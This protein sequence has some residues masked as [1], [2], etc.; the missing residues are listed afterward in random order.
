[1]SFADEIDDIMAERT[2]GTNDGA[3]G[4]HDENLRS[5]QRIAARFATYGKGK[6]MYVHGA[7]WHQWDGSRW[8]P[9]ASDTR[10][11]E[12]LTELLT[13][14]WS[15]AMTDRDLQSDV[16]A[17]MTAMGSRGVLELARA[18]RDLFAEHVDRDPWLL[19]CLNG[20]LDLHTLALR[21]HDPGDRITR[22]CGAAYRPDA[23]APTWKYL[24]ESSLPDGAVRGY[25]QRYAGLALVGRVIEHVLVIMTGEG[26]NGKGLIGHTIGKALG[27]TD[28]YAITGAASMLVAGRYGD[29]PS[30]GE[31]AAQY[32]LRGARWVVLSEIQRGS[33]MDQATMKLLTGGDAIQA[34]RMGMDPID[35]AP[36]HTLAM[37]ANDL[38]MVD[39][40]AKAVWDRLRVIPFTVDFSGREDTTIEERLESELEGVLA[41]CVEGLRDYM[42][43]GRK[44]DAPE[45]VWARTD[46]YRDDNDALG[47]F[48]AEECVEHGGAQ[49]AKSAFADAYA[50]WA[51]HERE[52]KF[53]P[54][55]IAARL[56]KRHGITEGRPNSRTRTWV[57]IGL[58]S[59]DQPD[60]IEP[61]PEPE[62]ESENPVTRGSVT[63]VTS[64]VRALRKS[65]IGNDRDEVTQVTQGGAGCAGSA[66]EAGSLGRVC[67]VCGGVLH[68]GLVEDT[69]PGCE[70]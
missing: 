21:P 22:V 41:W 9:D 1:M 20:T 28:G 66:N 11:N 62:P 65:N 64:T 17:A 55:A 67:R 44:L 47:R 59:R 57:G 14:S 6:V 19:N 39:P 30:A 12:L 24:T 54:K 16:R 13:V 53:G 27:N 51:E 26:R 37:L 5:H 40:D 60:E 29:K 38:P 33:R 43:R 69:H 32:R 68:P 15:E 46:A 50:V 70:P 8:A 31:L 61:E 49:V 4:W 10:V 2:V 52:P 56:A 7:G 42:E 36:S 63:C 35:F 48:I 45:A 18:H 34:K 25:L 23:A 3:G 58:R